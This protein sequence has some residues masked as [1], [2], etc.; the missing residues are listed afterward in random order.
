MTRL[1]KNLEILLMMMAGPAP[2]TNTRYNVVHFNILVER[3][4]SGTLVVRPLLLNLATGISPPMLVSEPSRT[5]LTTPLGLTPRQ[6]LA[7]ALTST[8]ARFVTELIALG[9]NLR[10]PSGRHRRGRLAFLAGH[11]SS[12]A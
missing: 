5:R 8:Q 9:L 12:S 1:A 7:T 4:A 6:C 3:T 11:V 2:L 10:C